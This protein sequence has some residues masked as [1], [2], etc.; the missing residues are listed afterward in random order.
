MPRSGTA[1]PFQR[2][3]CSVKTRLNTDLRY[4]PFFI[5]PPVP[6]VL[7]VPPVPL[8]MPLLDRLVVALFGDAPVPVPM[9][10]PVPVTPGEP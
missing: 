7:F 6:F 1:V 3:F 8:L 4:W 2:R 5:V 9:P 10:P